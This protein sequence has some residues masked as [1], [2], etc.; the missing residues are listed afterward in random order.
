VLIKTVD[1]KNISFKIATGVIILI[2]SS[3]PGRGEEMRKVVLQL[4]W[5]HQFQFAGYYAAEKLGYYKNENLEVVIKPGG[6]WVNVVEEVISGRSNFGVG[7]SDVLLDYAKGKP[8]VV[9]GV[10][11]QHSPIILLMKSK[12][13]T[14]TM[15]ELIGQ[16]VMIEPSSADISV[17]FRRSGLSDRRI[18]IMAHSNRIEDLINGKIKAVS[19]YITTEP[20]FL[21]NTG[22]PYIVFSPRSYGIDF[23]GDNF[24]TSKE[25]INK[26]EKT[27]RSFR[28]ATIRGWEYAKANPDMVIEWILKEYNPSISKDFLKFEANRSIDLMT[29]LVKPGFMN[30]DRWNFIAETYHE[31]GMLEAVP[32]MTEFFFE[33]PVPTALPQW[34]IPV[35]L[36]IVV[37][38]V[39]LISIA[40]HLRRL[41]FR[42]KS[43]IAVRE[44]TERRLIETNESLKK[45][46]SK[47][48]SLHGILPI[49][50]YCK[51]IRDDKGYWSQ[52]EVYVKQN[53]DADF[54]HSI[55][56]DCVK[57]YY[58]NLKNSNHSGK[59]SNE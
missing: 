47:I 18:N 41:N 33:D 2:L 53:S 9:L 45:A 23:Y 21:E 38:S 5:L 40:D 27:V 25:M 15:E 1:L 13:P 34:V 57:I 29:N 35:I 32:D 6:P 55:C 31:A 44:T 11:Y 36:L 8:V 42:L 46:V 48:K 56:P 22:V 54:S 26:D 49:C 30:H 50:S 59:H 10:I 43:E 51:K 58:P 16:K 3:A 7:T 20:Y 19:A 52:V 37:S 17:M 28:N 4:K 24:F 12:N 39:F 14:A